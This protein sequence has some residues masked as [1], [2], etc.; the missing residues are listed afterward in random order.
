MSTFF[1]AVSSVAIIFLLTAVGYYCAA[2]RWMGPEVKAFISRYL[3]RLAI[4]FMCTHSL[5]KNLSRELVFSSAKLLLLCILGTAIVLGCA[6]LAGKLLHLPRSKYG[7]FVMMAGLSNA[8]FIGYAMCSE[9]FG[10]VC[11]PYVMLYYLV[12]TSCVQLIGIPMIRWSGEN[13]GFSAQMIKKFLTAPTVLSVF[14]GFALVFLNWKLPPLVASFA[15]YLSNTV[16][17]LALFLT[18]CIIYEIGLENLKLDKSIAAVLFARF[19]FAP[20]VCL[21]LCAAF[22]VTGLARS[23]FTVEFAMPVVSQTI[24]AATEYGADAQYAAR[25]IA[26][27]TLA[28]FVVIPVLM[29]LL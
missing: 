21:A 19:L 1:N 10:E 4:P 27:T 29:V 28:C 24:V 14:V 9:L 25:G 23:V 6:F 18:G 5:V 7:V 15:G 16:T 8:L 22:G 2:R 12:N 17:P 26:V 13:E 11:T 3:M 20:A